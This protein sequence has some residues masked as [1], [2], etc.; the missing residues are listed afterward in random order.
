MAEL[1]AREKKLKEAFV[2]VVEDL[3]EAGEESVDRI[4]DHVR[5]YGTDSDHG[6]MLD[7]AVQEGL[8]NIHRSGSVASRIRAPSKVQRKKKRAPSRSPRRRS[9]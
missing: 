4:V 8:E 1:T 7:L 6:I 9:T 5:E 3:F 2:R